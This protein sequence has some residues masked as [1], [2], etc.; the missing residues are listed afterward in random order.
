MTRGENADW[1]LKGQT[2]EVR[3]EKE[4]KRQQHKTTRS[5][6]SKLNVHALASVEP[7]AGVGWGETETA[8]ELAAAG[9]TSD[10]SAR[11]PR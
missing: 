9:A 8:E 3:L 4:G 7:A 2:G 1:R 10:H 5:Q 6:E 11:E